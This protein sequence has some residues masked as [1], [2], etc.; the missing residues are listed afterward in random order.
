MSNTNAGPAL[1][2]DLQ[3]APIRGPGDACLVHFSYLCMLSRLAM[4]AECASRAS[5]WAEGE[6]V[7]HQ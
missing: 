4:G 5:W 3:V 6:N 7:A 2:Q 1:G